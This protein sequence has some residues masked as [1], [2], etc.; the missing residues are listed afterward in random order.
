MYNWP[1]WLGLSNTPTASLLRSK[2]PPL[3]NECPG[4][5]IKQSDGG[6]PVML[7]LWG[8]LSAPS[9]SLWPRGVAP[10]RVLSM[11]LTELFDI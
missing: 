8:M 3:P 1:S 4:Y 7:E 2:I 5:D 6:A 11:S 10:D 9:G